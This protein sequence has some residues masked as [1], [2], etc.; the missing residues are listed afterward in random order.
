[1]RRESVDYYRGRA[2]DER[3]AALNA[4]C[5]EARR[6]HNEMAKAYARLVELHD[7]QGRGAL[8]PGKV[9]S[10]S[11]ILHDRDKA[12]YGGSRIHGAPGSGIVLKL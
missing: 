2:S 5:D 12:E 6:A 9:T 3:E 11:E 8:P 7:L 1:L 4:S 10:M